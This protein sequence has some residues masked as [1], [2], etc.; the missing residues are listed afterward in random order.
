MTKSHMSKLVVIAIATAA[1]GALSMTLPATAAAG[2]S[3]DMTG[4]TFSQ[5]KAAL[6]Q[7]GYTAVSQITIGDRTAS[8]D[9]K[10]IRQEDLPSAITGWS[11]SNISSNG[12][13]IGGDQPTLY[14]G[15]G[16]GDIPAS[17]RVLLTLSCYSAN[18]ASAS[19]PTGS[20]DITTKPSQ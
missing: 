8:G 7:A 1:A 5:A 17:G 10:V 13:F 9:C 12:V 19:H 4:K 14:P 3:P 20:G 2:G 18:D 16:F 15:P 11:A 6:T